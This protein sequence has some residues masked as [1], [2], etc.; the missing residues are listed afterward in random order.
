MNIL[1][2]ISILI[3]SGLCIMQTA[4][5]LVNGAVELSLILRLS[6]VLIAATVVSIV[7]TT[8][9]F[10]VSVSS[11][12]LGHSGMA[13]GNAIGSCICNIGLILAVGMIIKN[14]KIDKEEL[15]GKIFIL[16]ASLMVI[17][18]LGMNGTIGRNGA[19][20]LFILLVLFMYYNYQAAVKQRKSIEQGITDGKAKHNIFKSLLKIFTGGFLTILL[21]RY[22]LVNPGINIANFLGVPSI[23][24]GLTLISVGTSLPELFTAIVSSRKGHGEIA[25]GNVVGANI[26]N[27]L[28]VLGAAA[29]VRPVNIDAQTMLFNIPVAIFFAALIM[30]FGM[31]SG[32]F[33]RA[34]GLT[35]LLFYL[36]YVLTLFLVLYRRQ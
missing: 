5:L 17:L 11:S 14:I 27:V 13:V 7:T 23:L 28:W 22:G 33:N 25:L 24:I 19:A 20:L 36:I 4:E 12:L 32:R 29:M 26:L 30:L 2:D 6:K 9:E 31:K 35:L 10:I 34:N 1:I 18:L 3:G 16:L 8:P 21:A 15:F